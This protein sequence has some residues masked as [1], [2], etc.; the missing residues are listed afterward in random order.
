MRCNRTGFSMGHFHS[1]YGAERHLTSGRLLTVT[2]LANE[3]TGS[4][5]YLELDVAAYSSSP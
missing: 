3:W 2:G 4:D 5:G 1:G